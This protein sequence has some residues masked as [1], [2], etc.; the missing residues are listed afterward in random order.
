MGEPEVELRDVRAWD[1][2][3]CECDNNKIIVVGQRF[4]F[5]PWW[6]KLNVLSL[7]PE[8]SAFDPPLLSVMVLFTLAFCLQV[9]LV[10]HGENARRGWTPL[11]EMKEVNWLLVLGFTH[12]G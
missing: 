8:G 10:F 4:L 12:P 5:N 2:A 3:E 6:L 7:I 1:S 9:L 11:V